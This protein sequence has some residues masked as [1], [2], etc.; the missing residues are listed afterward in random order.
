MV[1]GYF[2]NGQAPGSEKFAYKMGW[3]DGL[4]RLRSR[5]ELKQHPQLV[6]M[7]DFNI[8]PED[9][10]VVRPRGPVGRPDPRTRRGARALP[11]APVGLGLHDGF[12]LLRAAAEELELVGLPHARATSKNQGLRIDHILV[13]E[14]LRG[15]VRG[16]AIDRAPRKWKQPSDHAPVTVEIG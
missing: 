8:A 5:E 11:A 7:G 14:P 6:L 13:S 4:Q 15:E 9:R 16:C 3:L 2:V 10:D 1:N 12:R